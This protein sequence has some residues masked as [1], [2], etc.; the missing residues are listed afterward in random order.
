[1]ANSQLTDVTS[2]ILQGSVLSSLLLLIFVNDLP[3]GV[4]S[5]INLFAD[6]TKLNREIQTLK[7][8]QELQTD[9]FN[10]LRNGSCL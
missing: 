9:L 8:S 10:G 1:M 5:T 6:V 7:D 2:H 3:D 4:S